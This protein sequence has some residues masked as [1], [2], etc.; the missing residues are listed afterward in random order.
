MGAGASVGLIVGGVLTDLVSWRWVLFINVPLGL[1]VALLAPRFVRRPGTHP[2]KFDVT[3]AI[4]STIGMG[5]LVYAFIQVG[6]R[7][8]GDRTAQAAFV[9]AAATLLAFFLIERRV[10]QPIT[11]LHLFADAGRAGAYTA[12]LLLTAA[13]FSVLFLLTQ[14]QQDV[15]G[16]TPIRAGLAFLPMTVMQFFA[17]RLV[18]K[19]LP[20][21]GAR[22]L[23]IAG[24]LLIV[25]GMAWLTQLST[26]GNY[27]TMIFVPLFLIGLGV[28]ISFP[29][30]N[31]TIM[32]GVAP[33]DSG[34][35]SGLLQTLQW[36]GGT[37]GLAIFVTVLGS[38]G[39]GVAGQPAG[40]SAADQAAYGLTHGIAAAFLAAGISAAGALVPAFFA[41]GRPAT[42][43]QEPQPA[44]AP[45]TSAPSAR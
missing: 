3:G 2:A 21:T 30:L 33:Q 6:S 44:P 18:P 4:T 32:S 27:F 10:T 13:M 16:F 35:A 41:P 37:L 45:A 39:R 25:G 11:P 43:P 22:P 28:G 38:A 20:R 8:W 36:L 19:L 14:F 5:A 7:G 9:V 31:M 34:A 26:T 15:L 12:T 40:A 23:L 42:R 29:T 1:A 17:V 24:A